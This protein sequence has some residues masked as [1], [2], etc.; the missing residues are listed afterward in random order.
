MN[1]MPMNDFTSL[2]K[3]KMPEA[4]TSML[5]AALSSYEN[6]QKKIHDLKKKGLI[7]SV[8]QG[9]YIMNQDLGFRP[10]ANEVLANLIYGPSYISLETAL[11]EY[12]FIPEQVTVTTSISYGRGKAFSSEFGE[13]T[14]HHLKNSLYSL[15]VT[16]KEVAEAAYCQYATP[17]KALFDFLYIRENRGEF[18][19][20]EDYFDYITSAYRL[21][22][23]AVQAQIAPKKMK[24]YLQH[25]SRQHIHWFMNELIRRA[26]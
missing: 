23:K 25:T 3:L 24:S 21:D 20:Q 11:S 17:E 18:E 19:S 9:V 4:T 15:G 10:P 16:S 26:K 2:K 13:F 8:K 7:R 6:P 22:L 1:K 5:L 12:G 14:Y